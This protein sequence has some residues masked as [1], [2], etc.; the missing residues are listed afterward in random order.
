MEALQRSIDD[1]VQNF[2]TM[3]ADKKTVSSEVHGFRQQLEDFGED[4]DG[5]KRRLVEPDKLPVPPRVEIPQANKGV[6]AAR[7]TNNGLPL[8]PTP[9]GPAGF[10]TTPSSLT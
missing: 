8:I 2:G 9:S 7:L 1:L 6:M 5:V 10:V 4:I 3:A